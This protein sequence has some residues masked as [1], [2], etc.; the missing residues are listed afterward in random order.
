MKN[1]MVKVGAACLVMGV[2]PEAVCFDSPRI[3]FSSKARLAGERSS[4]RFLVG[5]PEI[6]IAA[7]IL[8]V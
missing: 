5:L 6:I 4:L 8:G 3:L 7:A 1:L 2:S